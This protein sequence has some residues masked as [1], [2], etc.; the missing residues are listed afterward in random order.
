MQNS[1]NITSINEL[2]LCQ[3]EQFIIN[4]LRSEFDSE[5]ND[6]FETFN[7][8]SINWDIVY[9]K[10]IQWRIAPLL[11]KIIEK[12]SAFLQTSKIPEHFTKRMK[13]IYLG[14]F[15][16]NY[17]NLEIFDEALEIFN[18]VGLK[19]ILLKGSHLARF[20]YQDVGL[21]GMLDIDILVKK[22]D[23][24]KAEELLLQKGYSFLRMSQDP[25]KHFSN[26]EWFKSKHSHLHPFIHP[27]GTKRI[28]IHWTIVMPTN[29]LN[30]NIEKLWQRANSVR[31]NETYALVLS[32]EDLLLY[33][34][35]H[36]SY[37][38]KF[39]KHGLGPY[40][41]IA[42][43]IRYY[44]QDIDWDQLKLRAYE[45]RAEKYLYLTLRLSK[46]ILGVSVPDRILH[47]LKPEPFNEKMALEA[48]KRILY[49]ENKKPAFKGMNYSAKIHIFHPEDS[50]L[51][52]VSFFLK[53]IFISSEELASRYSLPASSKRVHLYHIVR[54]VSL[55][56]SY[57][58]VYS[59]YFLY[60]LVHKKEHH[61]NYNL[62]LWL[63]KIKML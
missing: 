9:K 33:L 24:R 36:T 40:C 31:I 35:L 48:R 27:K 18:K 42:T 6:K 50:L 2:N 53:R 15:T 47:A 56:Y 8:S 49:M 52:K 39:M 12:R 1:I 59:S 22:E 29:L 63:N 51:K 58:R 10:S 23:L 7:F 30:I 16:A 26:I 20:V 62:D 28:E 60:R 13:I 57:T 43:T 38:H 61:C 45:W 11:Y 3:E 14:T 44:N 19:V 37:Q 54:F 46:E 55:L 41:D 4:C 17:E 34:S 5:N 32:P 25:Q 21:R